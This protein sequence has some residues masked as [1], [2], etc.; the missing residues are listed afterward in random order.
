MKDLKGLLSICIPTYNRC[1][2]LKNCIGSIVSQ[3]AFNEIE[4]VVSD[5]ASTDDTEKLMI[6]FCEQFPNIKYYRNKE[7]LGPDKNFILALSYASSKYLMLLSDDDWLRKD[8]YEKLSAYLYEKDLSFIKVGS[9]ASG[10]V[11]KEFDKKNIY[12]F[13][14]HVGIDI[15]FMSTMIFNRK[16]LEQVEN[17]EK[18]IGSQF[19]QTGLVIESIKKSSL[20][21]G[22]FEKAKIYSSST[23]TLSYNF[24]DIF[25]VS[26]KKMYMLMPVS[27]FKKRKLF[28]D[29]FKFDYLWIKK[30][31]KNKTLGMPK[32]KVYFAVC[33]YLKAWI[34]L[35][36]IMLMPKFILR[37][38]SRVKRRKK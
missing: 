30:L 29:T 21:V 12:E 4:I 25:I 7:N 11:A 28:A 10:D 37:L 23:E 34:Y 6:S 26:L 18:Y 24:Y 15:T 17:A 36:P 8:F 5:N 38:C 13:F 33:T 31:K 22:I 27:H 19:I 14:K 1:E 16:V 2:K 35:I 32:L 3:K 20:Q 9:E